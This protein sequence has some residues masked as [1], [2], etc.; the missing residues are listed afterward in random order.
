MAVDFEGVRVEVQHGRAKGTA[1]GPQIASKGTLLTVSGVS[2]C[3]LL[4]MCLTYHW[5]VGKSATAGWRSDREHGAVR[6]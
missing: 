5:H 2:P 6:A 1:E 3:S 4:G